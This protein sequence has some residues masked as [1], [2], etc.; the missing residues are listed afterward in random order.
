M[1]Y[2]VRRNSQPP[3]R[4]ELTIAVKTGRY[5]QA[6]AATHPHQ[7]AF[8]RV[9][10][11]TMLVCYQQ[12]PSAA[13][14]S[15]PPSINEEDDERGIAHMLE[16]LTFRAR[17]DEAP[18]VNFSLVK[19]LEAKGLAF[20]AHQNAYTNFDETVYFLHVPLDTKVGR[21]Q[22]LANATRPHLSTPVHAK[23]DFT[24][25][26]HA[27]PRHATYATTRRHHTTRSTRAASSKKVA[28][29]TSSRC[30]TIAWAPSRAL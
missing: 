10:Q 7:Y 17:K 13:V 19:A 26:R 14:N 24:T 23:S 22:R 2:Y 30:S 15:S 20:G 16:H 6:H 27:T 29:V 5:D 4:A 8:A 25:P 21:R 28:T 9:Q 3:K 1:S 11:S 18:E 12:R